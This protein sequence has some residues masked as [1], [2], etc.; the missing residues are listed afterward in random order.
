MKITLPEPCLVAL[1]GVSG[2][3]KSTFAAQHFG[4]SEVV[5]SDAC[6]KLVSDDEND[7]SATAAAFE[8]LYTIARKRLERGLLT[9]VDA[10]NARREDRAPIVALAKPQHLFACAIVID[11]PAGICRER[12]RQRTDRDLGDHVIGNQHGA[13]AQPRGAPP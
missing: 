11:V 10:T 3:G 2:S 4:D 1:V 13:A 9:V 6:R 8:V 7:Q 12:N 5:S